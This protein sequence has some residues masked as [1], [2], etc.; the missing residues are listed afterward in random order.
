MSKSPMLGSNGSLYPWI[1][2]FVFA[3]VGAALLAKESY[4]AGAFFVAAAA[5]VRW[6]HQIA[7]DRGED[8]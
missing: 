7:V 1:A 8:P 5:L 6:L 4:L 3:M 2:P